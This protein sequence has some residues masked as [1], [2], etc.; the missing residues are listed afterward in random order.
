LNFS[1]V[2]LN[3]GI[4][5]LQTVKNVFYGLIRTISREL[6]D[7]QSVNLPDWG[8]FKLHIHKSRRSMNVYT[9]KIENLPP[10][11]TVKFVPDDNV[12]KYFYDWGERGL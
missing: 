2:T 10:K 11:T 3:S 8:E 1:K 12:K 6:R 9:R 7:N 4:S 5:D